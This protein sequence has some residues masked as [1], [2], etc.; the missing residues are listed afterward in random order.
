MSR[1]RFEV[2]LDVD[3]DKIPRVTGLPPDP[4]RWTGYDLLRADES[5]IVRILDAVIVG[6]VMEGAK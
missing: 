6:D 4:A 5:G 3:E 1:Y 2:E